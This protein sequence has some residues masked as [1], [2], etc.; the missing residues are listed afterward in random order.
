MI[1]HEY[2]NWTNPNG[3]ASIR[4][5]FLQMTGD[6]VFNFHAKLVADMHANLSSRSTAKTFAYWFEAFPSQRI[7]WTPTWITKPN[8]GDEL[9][10]LFGYDK[11]FS[12]TTPYSDDYKPPDWELKLSQLF[13]TLITNFVKSG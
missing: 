4:K 12:W 10:F 6:Y 1:I 2:T 8:H 5:S 11:E 7:L 13:M 3:I 9:T